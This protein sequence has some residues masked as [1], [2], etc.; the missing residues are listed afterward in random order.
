MISIENMY[1]TKKD[2]QENDPRSQTK[3]FITLGYVSALPIW[4]CPLISSPSLLTS[5]TPHSPQALPTRLIFLP[6]QQALS[7]AGFCHIVS[8]LSILCSLM[9][10]A[11]PSGCH[12]IVMASRSLF[13]SSY[14]N[15]H[16]NIHSF[17]LLYPLISPRASPLEHL[18]KDAGMC[19]VYY[20]SPMYSYDLRGG[21]CF[22]PQ[23]I[24]HQVPRPTH[25]KW[26]DMYRL[27]SCILA[28][29]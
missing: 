19:P 14:P 4:W 28:V 20:V 10:P 3:P 16:Q 22:A 24:F 7:A 5:Q 13:W 17:T 2:K 9:N 6:C 8:S 27:A 26:T 1:N 15:T 29:L 12:L 21:P 25:S 23:F 11:Y 18:T